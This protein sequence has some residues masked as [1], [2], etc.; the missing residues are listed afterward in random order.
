MTLHIAGVKLLKAHPVDCTKVLIYDER[1]IDKNKRKAEE[2]KSTVVS[3]S[4][5]TIAG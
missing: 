2:C 5:N 1:F 4:R 3:L